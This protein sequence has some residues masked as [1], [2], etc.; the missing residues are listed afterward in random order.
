[1]AISNS[2]GFALRSRRFCRLKA[3]RLHG[4]LGTLDSEA[5]AVGVTDF[6]A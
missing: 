6:S 1:L 5:N 2:R 3:D 4:T